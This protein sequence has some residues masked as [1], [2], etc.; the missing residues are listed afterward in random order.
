MVCPNTSALSLLLLASLSASV[1]YCVPPSCEL[2]KVKRPLCLNSKQ[3]ES[4]P[5]LH[6]PLCWNEHGILMRER[7]ASFYRGDSAGG[8]KKGHWAGTPRDLAQILFCQN[9]CSYALWPSLLD[10]SNSFAWTIN[11]KCHCTLCL[12]IFWPQIRP[13]LNLPLAVEPLSVL[14]TWG[15]LY[16]FLWWRILRCSC[17]SL[18]AGQ[19]PP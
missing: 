13:L 8:K 16:S 17:S 1:S 5:Q 6:V 11:S 2:G 18:K 4:A 3:V 19:H 14:Q 9:L 7:S 12:P 15:Q 10:P